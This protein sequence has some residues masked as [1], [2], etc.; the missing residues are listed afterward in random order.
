MDLEIRDGREGDAARVGEIATDTWPDRGVE[1][2]VGDAYPRWVAA[3]DR[4]DRRVLV[5]ERAGE[6]VAVMRGLLLS[7]DEGW[8]SGLRVA[9]E[10]RGEGVGARLTRETLSW[11]REAGATVCRNLVHGWNAP[12]LALSRATGFEPVTAFRFVEPTPD[13]NAERS[14]DA[15]LAAVD[16]AEAARSFWSAGDARSAL[17]GLALDPAEAWAF[18]TLTDER[19]RTAAGEGRLFAVGRGERVRGLAV[20]TRVTTYGDGDRIAEYGVGAWRPGD[21]EAARAL[22][23]AVARDAAAVEAERTRVVVPE[24]V[25]WVT[26][27]ASAGAGLADGPEFVLA[28]DL[29]GGGETQTT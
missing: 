24:R 20:R 9:H 25:T 18:S 15:D 11:L 23:G 13:A 12:S 3:A 16:D 14:P 2:Y 6:V 8:A 29:S 4:D 21:V 26:D 27:A 17:A 19:V 10:A 5:A 7:D 22:L 28:T 1:D